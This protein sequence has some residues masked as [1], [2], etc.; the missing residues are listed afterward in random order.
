MTAETIAGQ[1]DVLSRYS[2]M[3]EELDCCHEDSGL[4]L[5]RG[6]A[7]QTAHSSQLTATPCSARHAAQRTYAFDV[8]KLAPRHQRCMH[9]RAHRFDHVG[10]MRALR[11]VASAA[12]PV[13]PALPYIA[14]CQYFPRSSN[15]WHQRFYKIHGISM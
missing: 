7:L 13:L 8:I 2:A 6:E 15:D 4:A 1:R 5:E 14:K 9:T 11:G 12:W 3:V 10:R